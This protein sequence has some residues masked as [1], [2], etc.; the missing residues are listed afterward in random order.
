MILGSRNLL[1]LV[2][3]SQAGLGKPG[4]VDGDISHLAE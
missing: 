3:E 1:A 4:I 2:R